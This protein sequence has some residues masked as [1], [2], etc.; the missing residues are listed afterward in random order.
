M[1]APAK[2]PTAGQGGVRQAV[3]PTGASAHDR[4]V[5]PFSLYVHIPYCDAKCPYCDFNSYAATRWPERAYA[6]ALLAE[7]RAAAQAAWQG[8]TVCTVFFGGGTPSLFA[9][10][11]IA[12]LLRAARGL[13]PFAAGAEVTL[14]ANPGTV[15][16][17]KL[18]GF[19][20]AGVNRISFGVQSF[21]DQHL[22]TLG[23]IHDAAEAV[24]A[25]TAARA[26]GFDNLNLD[27]IFAVP[28]QT[29]EQ[30][31]ADLR[32]ALAFAPEHIS[33]YGLTYEENTPFHVLRRSGALTPLPEEAEV[34]MFTHTRA[35]LADHGY[36]AYEI[37]NFARPGRACAHNRNYWRAG[38]YLGVGAGAHSFAL[39]PAPGLRWGNE[40]SPVRY[41]ARATATGAARASEERLSERQARG[42]FAFLGLRCSEGFGLA[43]FEHRFG[44]SADAAFPHLRQLQRDD[45]V[46]V[47]SG[48]CRLTPRGLLIADSV[49]ATFL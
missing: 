22:R 39:Q 13:W 32:A 46:A 12:E 7:M 5:T 41:I 10:A 34:A 37:S 33:A 26:A 49:F 27:L 16:E 40:K 42:E 43:D 19:R 48:R 17:A 4:R 2:P 30:W 36:E 25:I 20:Q 47:G 18:R 15:D 21:H 1:S 24:A 11:T 28:G 3:A 23:R 29:V 31:D 8:Y 35:V 45:L 44:C 14:E 38:A 6:E 9:P